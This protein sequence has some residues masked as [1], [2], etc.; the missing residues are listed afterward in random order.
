MDTNTIIPDDKTMGED[1][2]LFSTL[3]FEDSLDL[4]PNLDDLP[5]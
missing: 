1:N 3:A 2:L 4:D 5:L